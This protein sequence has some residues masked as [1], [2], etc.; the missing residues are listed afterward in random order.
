M[1]FNSPEYLVFFVLVFG[2]SW[3]L[4][5]FPSLR[6]WVLLLASYF[7]YASNNSWLIA[8]ILVS[9]QI[10]FWVAKGIED[11][12]DPRRRRRLLLVSVCANLGLLG[13]F[14]YFNFFVETGVALAGAV[15]AE[16]DY[17][18]LKILLPVGISFYTFQSMS[19]TIDVYRGELRAERSWSRFAF[20]VAF[21]PQLVAGPIMRAQE[22]MPQIPR[23]PTLPLVDFERAVAMIGRGLLKKMV[24]A[25]YFLAPYAD[26]AFDHPEQVGCLAAWLGLY[27]FTFQIYF[28]FSGYTDIAIG[29]SRLLGYH[30]PDNFKLPYVAVS[31]SDFWRRWH[32]SL[33]SWLRDYLYIPLGGNRMPSEAGIYRNLMLTMLL[34]GLWHGAAWHFVLW[35]ALHGLYLAIERRWGGPRD[36]RDFADRG[37]LRLFGRRLLIFHAV[38][39]TWLVFRAQDM[40]HLIDLCRVLLGGGEQETVLRGGMLLCALVVVGSFVAQLIGA[41]Y[42]PV[43]GF[44]R[45]PL[46]A[47][48]FVYSA[49]V[50]AIAVF[51]KGAQPFIYFQF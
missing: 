42:T 24:L 38:V 6:I 3:A 15:G 44:L 26:L 1:L 31:F 45:L 12:D 16:V 36:A 33:S 50:G 4:R 41:A 14:K 19:Y 21:F 43:R 30:L 5:G 28:D 22:F 17:T 32:I 51:N 7:F 35:G 27:A 9:T 25:D 10:D 2:V 13:F 39:L 37:P 8:L 49:L 48:A 20:Y 11:S 18:P 46:P 47:R 29:C 40:P 23:R 34:G